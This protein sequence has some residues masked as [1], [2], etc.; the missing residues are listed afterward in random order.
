[1]FEHP[2][3]PQHQ[4]LF[5]AIDPASATQMQRVTVSS[6]LARA[7]NKIKPSSLSIEDA[8]RLDLAQ[9]KRDRKAS[10]RAADR[11]EAVR[12]HWVCW[13]TK[14]MGDRNAYEVC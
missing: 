6:T 10:K 4:S 13:S 12:T 11:L 5:M 3:A 1:M 8:A 9:R 7:W 14:P 2:Q